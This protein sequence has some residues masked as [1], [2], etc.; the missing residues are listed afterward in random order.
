M[1]L[2]KIR[3]PV[4][5]HRLTGRRFSRV[6]APPQR[7]SVTPFRA[8]LKLETGYFCRYRSMAPNAFLISAPYTAESR[9]R[10]QRLF[11]GLNNFIDDSIVCRLPHLPQWIG[12]QIFSIE[13]SRFG[14]KFQIV[15]F[16]KAIVRIEV[17]LVRPIKEE[18]AHGQ[19]FSLS[20]V[21]PWRHFSRDGRADD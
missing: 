1:D 10:F 8:A 12:F 2:S 13:A 14:R 21:A 15:G 6:D 11:G 16:D 7:Y 3:V 17:S 9:K 18:E 4:P 5:S 20:L 19:K